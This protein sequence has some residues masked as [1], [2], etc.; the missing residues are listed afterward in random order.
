MKVYCEN[1]ALTPG[2][3]ALQ[4]S[5][6]ITLINFPHD[7]NTWSRAIS[8]SAKPSALQYRDIV[9]PTKVPFNCTYDELGVGSEMYP[10]ILAIVGPANRRDALHVDS[11]YQSGCRAFV[12]TDNDILAHRAELESL[13]SI[14]ILQADTAH[15]SLAK[16]AAGAV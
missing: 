15:E 7:P 2:L 11:A 13:L 10:R 6:V 1:G 16:L 5:G 12:T 9:L 14:A 3:R 4:K 8:P